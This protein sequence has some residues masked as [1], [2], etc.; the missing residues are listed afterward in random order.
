MSVV[1][2]VQSI[3]VTACRQR[4]VQMRSQLIDLCLDIVLHELLALPPSHLLLHLA[5]ALHRVL[6]QTALFT[7]S[8]SELSEQC[9]VMR[10]AGAFADR[11]RILRQADVIVQPV[12][13]RRCAGRGGRQGCSWGCW[14]AGRAR[15]EIVIVPC[16]SRNV[17]HCN[18]PTLEV[19]ESA[20][21]IVG[22]ELSRRA[23]SW[24]WKR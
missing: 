15:G 19:C 13:S 7:L 3:L 6:G 17:W 22:A 4:P 11:M 2:S 10:H 12:P 23:E 14:T 20:E 1:L 5:T 21:R 18:A 9:V 16:C 8:S 24:Q